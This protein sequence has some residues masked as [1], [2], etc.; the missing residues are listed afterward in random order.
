MKIIIPTAGEGTRLRPHTLT[1]AKVLLNVAGKPILGHILDPLVRLKPEKVIFI[2]SSHRE[3]IANYVHQNYTF[4]TGFIQQKR[5]LGLG[6]AV[7]L[8]LGEIGSEPVLIIL[9]DTIVE[10]SLFKKL[11]TK[12]DWLGVKPV[13][14]P[15]RFGIAEAE[16]GFA[17]K[18]VEKPEH[19]RGNLALVGLYYIKS[20]QI[21]KQ[22]LEH[23]INHK[24]TTR[25]EYQ[26]T[27]ALQ[28]MI[29]TGVKFKTVEI[30]EWYDCGKVET[31]L[32]TNRRLLERNHNSVPKLKRALV[33]PPVYI[34]RS[35]SINNSVVG[36]NVTVL[37]Q[38]I[39]D[40]SVVRNSILGEGSRVS[41]AVLDGSVIGQ[42]ARV[43]G[44]MRSINLGDL[45]EIGV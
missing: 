18:L 27:D 44:Q 33:L 41:G 19:P 26:L 10:E 40:N 11:D 17:K 25:G 42:K 9:G 8:A 5:P 23:I 28:L 13:K 15:H 30:K 2:V 29:K 4:K 32:E 14:D 31:L 45:S 20:T 34:A 43:T 16:N 7:S 3:K 37:E 6:H 1:Q 38:A 12:R 35:A 24:I 22:A 21:F 39:I 36:P